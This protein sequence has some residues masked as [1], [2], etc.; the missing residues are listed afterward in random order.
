MLMFV[1]FT[2]FYWFVAIDNLCDCMLC[3]T[4][5]RPYDYFRLGF[6]YRQQYLVLNYYFIETNPTTQ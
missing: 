6:T 2:V 5:L 4:Y 3:L 1:L